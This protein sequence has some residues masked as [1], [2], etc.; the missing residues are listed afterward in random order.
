MARLR[1]RTQLLVATLLIVL[2]LL[3]AVLLVV[4]HSMRSEIAE[5]LR[6]RTNASLQVVENIQQERDLQL[7]RTA[8]MLAELPTL[9]GAMATR[10]AMTI[11]DASG[12]FWKLAASELF[13][14]SDP[15]GQIFTLHVSK[16]GWEESLA[17]VELKN[18]IKQGVN[19][20]WWYG[21]GQLYR[22]FLRPILAGSQN[23][24]RQLGIIA[25]GYQIDSTAAAQAAQLSASQIAWA[26]NDK[27]IASTLSSKEES[28]LE[29]KSRLYCDVKAG[30][31][32]ISLGTDSYQAATVLI[33]EGLPASVR[34]YVLKSLQ[35]A[36]AFL[37]RLNRT[38]A[39]LG[40][41]VIVLA[42]VLLNFASRMI[43]HPLED[44]ISD[45]GTLA[46]REYAYSTKLPG[47]RETAELGE[48]FSIMRGEVLTFEQR[49]FATER[50]AAFGR[51]ASALSHDLRHYLTVLVANAEFLYEAEKLKLNRNEIYDEIKT[52]SEQ[53]TDLLDSLRELWR[54]EPSISPRLAAIDQTI[55]HA[56]DAV[57]A[58][59]EMRSRKILWHTSGEMTGMFD[60]HKIERAFLNLVLN[61]L[62]ASAQSQREIEIDIRSFAGQFEIRVTDHG[63]G[64][65]P[66][67]RET[68]FDPFVSFGKSTGSGLGLAIV[69]K[70]IHDHAGHVAM[71][72]T[73]QS[74][75][76]FLVKLPRAVSVLIEA[77]ER[78]GKE[79]CASNLAFGGH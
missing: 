7:F 19:S 69:N 29:K 23:H 76:T 44:L 4:R 60:P 24:E 36:N 17:Q 20:A 28:E 14:L 8:A 68:L 78:P 46:R 42:G 11:Q 56:V 45:V 1:L 26:I 74:G 53:M 75:T 66:L 54:T 10:H 51:A 3:T 13:V 41:S 43:A 32:E 50:A 79:P 61:A 18:S 2:T 62:E 25:V 70:I 27:I 31:H 58:R 71:E 77:G 9:K 35:P 59:A 15:G 49:R 39:I 64:V 34:C 63:P 73:S 55:R 47:N 33:Q 65:P 16:P 48:A 37:V 22:V 30:P 12:P 57:R 52:A 72:A 5:G 21:H 40:L 67:I 6:Q 38:I